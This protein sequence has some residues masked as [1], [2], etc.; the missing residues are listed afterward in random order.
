MPALQ[1]L[2]GCVLLLCGRRAY[3]LFVGALGFVFGMDLGARLLAHKPEY[4]TVLLSLC[5]GTLGA[6]VSVLVVKVRVVIA[7]LLAGAYLAKTGA[8]IAHWHQEDLTWCIAIV[9]GILGAV[10]ALLLFDWI[11]VL[12]SAIIGA[13]LAV[14][15]LPLDRDHL[16]MLF[17]TLAILGI[18]VQAAGLNHPGCGS[19]ASLPRHDA[20]GTNTNLQLK[21]HRR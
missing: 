5:I 14:E 2:T 19:A 10:L 9:G 20:L 17:A 16:L 3:W 12:S 6:L 7:G 18:A 4:L 21:I 8:E 15:P 13:Y 1:S 11:L